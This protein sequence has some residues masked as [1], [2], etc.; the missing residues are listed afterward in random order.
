VSDVRSELHDR[1][2][3]RALADPEFRRRLV[4]APRDAV[5]AELGIELPRGLEVVVVEEH[6]DLLAIVLPAD[7]SGLGADAVWAMTGSPPKSP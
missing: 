1:I 5:A 3:E 6:A 4:E 2:V 7:V